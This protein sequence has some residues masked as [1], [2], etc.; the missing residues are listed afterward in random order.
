MSVLTKK[1][2]SMSYLLCWERA[3]SMSALTKVTSSMSYLLCCEGASK[4]T[5]LWWKGFLILNAKLSSNSHS[6]VFMVCTNIRGIM[7]SIQTINFR[8]LVN[9]L[10]SSQ[11]WWRYCGFLSCSISTFVNQQKLKIHE[12]W[13]SDVICLYPRMDRNI[14]HFH[15]SFTCWLQISWSNSMQLSLKIQLQ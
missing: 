15:L 12:L 14:F 7:T 10:N 3:S 9:A 6:S 13:V 1:T 2:S 4:S 11:M 5:L 8:K